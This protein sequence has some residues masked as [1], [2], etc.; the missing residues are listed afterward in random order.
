[1]LVSL[2]FVVLVVGNIAVPKHGPPDEDTHSTPAQQNDGHLK[3]VP[4]VP[5]VSQPLLL[6]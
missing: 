3:K 1:M 4:L 6:H 5:E 2:V